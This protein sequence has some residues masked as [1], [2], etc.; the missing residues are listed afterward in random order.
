[1]GAATAIRLTH[2]L[3]S[4]AKSGHK[5]HFQASGGLVIEESVVALRDVFEV[6]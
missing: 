5:T 6:V 4:P 1:M 2:S 3:L